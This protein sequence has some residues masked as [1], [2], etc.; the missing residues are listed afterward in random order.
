MRRKRKMGKEIGEERGEGAAGQSLVLVPAWRR[1]GQWPQQRNTDTDKK[2]NILM[3]F[4]PSSRDAWK[5]E[6]ERK[7]MKKKKQVENGSQGRLHNNEKN[8]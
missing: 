6:G 8:N 1:A 2:N 4:Q 5:R 3:T 7:E